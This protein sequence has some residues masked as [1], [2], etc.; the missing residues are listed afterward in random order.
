MAE[1]TSSAHPRDST[2]PG[3]EVVRQAQDGLGR[4]G[5]T[6]AAYTLAF[7]WGIILAVPLPPPKLQQEEKHTMAMPPA[8]QGGAPAAAPPITDLNLT[9]D[10]KTAV[11]GALNDGT[12]VVVAYVDQEGQ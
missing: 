3:R 7:I 10:I 4:L 9:D 11:N 2:P 8:G 6:R 1:D 5:L 12:P